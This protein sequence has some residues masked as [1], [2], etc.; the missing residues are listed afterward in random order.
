LEEHPFFKGFSKSFLNTL[1]TKC[2]AQVFFVGETIIRQGD[3]ADSMIIISAASV[4]TLYVDGR[5]LKDLTGGCTLGIPSILCA[6]PVKRF[7][8]IEAQTACA[9]QKLRRKDWLDVLKHHAEHRLWIQSFTEEQLALASAQALETTR[10]YRWRKIKER[11]TLAVETHCLRARGGR[12]ASE[13]QKHVK[14]Q[15]HIATEDESKLWDCFNGRKAVVPHLRLPILT[16]RPPPGSVEG[17]DGEDLEEQVVR[18]A[19]TRRGSDFTGFPG[20]GSRKP[21]GG[22]SR[23][24]VLGDLPQMSSK[25]MSLED[26]LDCQDAFGLLHSHFDVT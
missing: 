25:P 9:V 24:S 3:P 6:A 18:A 13:P 22:S 8:T 16:P 23:L 1:R 20:V 17:S 14:Q 11:E 15:I 2:N 12:E 26:W 5:K 4:V 10:R 19:A 7:A 21:G